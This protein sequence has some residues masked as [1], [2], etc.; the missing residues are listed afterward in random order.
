MV[1]GGD[2]FGRTQGGNNN[3][4]C[5]DNEVSWYDWENVDWDLLA[6]TKTAIALRKQNP[7]LRPRDYLGAPEGG[8]AQM[9]LYRPDGKQMETS[10]WQDPHARALAMALDG[11]RIEDADG[12][13]T[14]DRFL[15]LL[16][17]HHQPVEFTIP[18]GRQAWSAVLTTGEPDETPSLTAKVKTKRT[19][20]LEARSLLLLHSP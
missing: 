1:L 18:R 4:Y 12:G 15:L 2:E 20:T 6:F 7:A 19:I 16:N 14:Q 9:V 13:T 5:Q 17:G 8:P 3:A 10:D 11:R